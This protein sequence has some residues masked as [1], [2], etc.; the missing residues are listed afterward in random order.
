MKFTYIFFLLFATTFGYSQNN[1][2]AEKA[3]CTRY[4]NGSFK[5]TGLIKNDKLQGQ[6]VKYSESGDAIVVGNYKDGRKEGKWLFV[7]ENLGVITEVKYS[8]NEV[9]DIKKFLYETPTALMSYVR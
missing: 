1:D 6:W 9:K 3:V 8:N 5:E 7:N 4:E 2:N